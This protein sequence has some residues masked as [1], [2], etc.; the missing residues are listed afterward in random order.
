V[1]THVAAVHWLLRC[2]HLTNADSG[3]NVPAATSGAQQ[4]HHRS[5]SNISSNSS[6]NSNSNSNINLNRL[7]MQV[8][9]VGGAYWVLVFEEPAVGGT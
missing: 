2:I 8:A 9:I 7:R 5:N 6:S 3:D 4:Q 1:P